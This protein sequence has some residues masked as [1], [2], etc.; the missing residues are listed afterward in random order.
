MI[1]TTFACTVHDRPTIGDHTTF[2]RQSPKKMI[3][4]Q[5]NFSGKLS[6]T[7]RD[8]PLIDFIGNYIALGKHIKKGFRPQQ[9]SRSNVVSCS[10]GWS[11]VYKQKWYFEN[12]LTSDFKP[13]FEINH[14]AISHS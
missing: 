4:R 7:Y 1:N 12:R 14:S 9:R 8:N 5:I 13:E 11:A 3:S 2:V 6:R 10:C